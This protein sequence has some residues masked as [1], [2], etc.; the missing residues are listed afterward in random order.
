MNSTIKR[1]IPAIGKMT[2][3]KKIFFDFFWWKVLFF[4]HSAELET[5]EKLSGIRLKK[6]KKKSKQIDS[7][8]IHNLE[9]RTRT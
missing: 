7:I 3:R 8:T 4:I 9:D 5:E 6:W 1:K 2:Q